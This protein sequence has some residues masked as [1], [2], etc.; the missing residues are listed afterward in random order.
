MEHDIFFSISQTPDHEGHIPSEQTMFKNYFQQLT[1]ADELGFGV[2]WIAQSHLSTETQ[3]SNSRPVVPHWKGEV[4]L[5]TD[6]PQLAMESFRQTS[7]I[8]IG[9][10]VVSILASGGPIAQAERI[11]NTLQLLAVRADKRK[12]HVGFSA[13]RFE[14]MARPYGIVPRTPTEEAAWPALRGQIFLEASE[15]FL[16]LLRGDV[17]HSDEIRSTELTRD[18]FRSDEDWERVQ[19]AHGSKDDSITIDRR[20]VFEDIRIVPNQFDRN[21]L[22]LVAGTHD[23]KAQVFVNKYLP[24]RVFN[25]SITQ[26]EVID[27][28]HE[29]MRQCF[30][31]DGGE[32]QRSDMPRTSFVFLNDEDGLTPEEQRIAAQSEADLS[33]SAYWNALEGTI[34]PSKVKNAAQNAL[35]GNVEDVAQQLVE[36]FHP[37]DRVM[38]WFDF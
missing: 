37:Q 12:L 8:E 18:N 20:Y 29:R 13:G 10:A 33:L 17:V 22:V 36:R 31:K 5:C 9:S 2:G 26:P 6:F 23:P 24:V 7:R 35:I 38:A 30:H 21:Q 32:W 3:K 15:I 16:R 14:F 28:T 11:A 19:N 4:G 25:L 27:A 34:D 1:L